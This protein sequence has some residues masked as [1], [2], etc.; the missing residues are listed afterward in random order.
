MELDR[1]QLDTLG[2]ECLADIAAYRTTARPYVIDKRP[3]N[4]IDACFI[5]LML[6]HA[7]F[8]DIRRAPMAAGFAM[9]KQMLPVDASFSFDLR[10]LGHYYRHYAGYMA[11]LDSVMP[12]RILV[13]SYDALVN[14]TE[15]EIRR[16]LAYCGLPFE[17]GCLRFWA[18]DRAVLTPSAEPVR[19]PIFRD[20][21]QQWTHYVPWLGP[22]RDALGEPAE[23]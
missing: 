12:G 6:P 8:I 13:L 19:R 10:H 23:A 4:W 9:F 17:A 21:L 14:D 16:M 2:Q 5:H 18:T 1:A 15:T 22:L 3:R 7:K 20:A 11:D